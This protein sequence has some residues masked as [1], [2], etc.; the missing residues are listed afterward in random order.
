MNDQ[1]IFYLIAQRT[2][3]ADY[4]NCWINGSERKE[5]LKSEVF[6]NLFT[7]AGLSDIIPDIK[8]DIMGT[9]SMYVI[10]FSNGNISLLSATIADKEHE[11]MEVLAKT[12]SIVDNDSRQELRKVDSILNIGSGGSAIERHEKTKGQPVIARKTS[13]TGDSMMASFQRFLTRFVK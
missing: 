7:N 12:P 4:I 2:Q 13:S 11:V 10:D 6:L 3:R 1:K 9:Y 5:L 8:K